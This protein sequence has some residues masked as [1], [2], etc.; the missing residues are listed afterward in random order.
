M[1]PAGGVG[2]NL[3]IQDAVAAANILAVP[4]RAGH[5]TDLILKRVQQRREFPTRITQ[6]LQVYAH[7]ALNAVFETDGP[8]QA[9]WQL[10]VIDAVPGRKWIV[11]YIV[12]VGVRPEH[13]ADAEGLCVPWSLQK[14]AIRLGATFGAIVNAARRLRRAY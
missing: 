4:L 6:Y 7:R 2:I 10:K 12:G 8:I 5:L 3:A 1:S 9:P 14:A 13:V 11:G